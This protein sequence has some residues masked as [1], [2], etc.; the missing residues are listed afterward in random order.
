MAAL[1]EYSLLGY[2]ISY[3]PSTRVTNY[4]VSA[5]LVSRSYRIRL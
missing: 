5:A 2:S 1:G 3:S 4:S